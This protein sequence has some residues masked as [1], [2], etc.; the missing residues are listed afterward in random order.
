MRHSG[1]WH[2]EDDRRFT[3]GPLA[4]PGPYRARLTVGATTVEQPF[5]IVSDPRVRTLGI[6]D[7]VIE[8]QVDFKLQT[9]DLLSEARRLARGL[10]DERD[11]LQEREDDGETLSAADQSRRETIDVALEALETAE[12]IYMQP[13]LIDQISYLYNM[14]KNADQE[15][16]GEARDRLDVLTGQLADVRSSVG[17]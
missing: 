16:G 14:V 7:D 4:K 17:E 3:D 8:S 6:T 13:M 15:P 11:A 10:Q 1:A 5:A 12:G 9:V 2:E